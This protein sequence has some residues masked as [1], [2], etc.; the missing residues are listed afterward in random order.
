MTDF[1]CEKKFTCRALGL[2]TTCWDSKEKS[3]KG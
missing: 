2:L 3:A 1:P